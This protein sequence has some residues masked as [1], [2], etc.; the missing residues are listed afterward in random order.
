MIVSG[1]ESRTLFECVR[2]PPI[3]KWSNILQKQHLIKQ[4]E[5]WANLNEADK[6]SRG[7]GSLGTFVRLSISST[8]IV[9]TLMKVKNNRTHSNLCHIK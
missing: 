9:S 4:C 8:Y 2:L 5:T 7:Q 1:D 3:R 6:I